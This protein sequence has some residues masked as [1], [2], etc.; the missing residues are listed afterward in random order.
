LSFHK[1]LSK[2]I[3]YTAPTCFRYR[4]L[5]HSLYENRSNYRPNRQHS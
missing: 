4:T 1:V 5:C 3:S 2:S